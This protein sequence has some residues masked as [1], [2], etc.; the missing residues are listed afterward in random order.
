MRVFFPELVAKFAFGGLQL[1]L[2]FEAAV[3]R[4]QRVGGQLIRVYMSC[5]Y[6][7]GQH[8]DTAAKT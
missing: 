7:I 1:A 4:S 6:I 8:G 5:R 2:F 3:I